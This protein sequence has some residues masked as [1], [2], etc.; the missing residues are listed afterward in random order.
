MAIQQR[1]RQLPDL[2]KAGEVGD[3]ILCVELP[4][5]GG[6]LLLGSSDE[7]NLISRAGKVPCRGCADTVARSRDN[8]CSW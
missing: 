1:L 2:V 3:E 8:N 6:R 4:R 7:D 5:D